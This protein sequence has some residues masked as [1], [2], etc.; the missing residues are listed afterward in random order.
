M[1]TFLRECLLCVIYQ[2]NFISPPSRLVGY[3]STSKCQ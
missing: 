3:Q 1:F 2:C